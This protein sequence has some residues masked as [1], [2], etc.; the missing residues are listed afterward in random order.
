VKEGL[1]SFRHC[2]LRLGNA[3]SKERERKEGIAANSSEKI[4]KNR[5]MKML[6]NLLAAASK[7]QSGNPE[8]NVGEHKYRERKRAGRWNGH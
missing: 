8:S 6:S 7:L 2:S 5:G 1:F 3:N 4:L